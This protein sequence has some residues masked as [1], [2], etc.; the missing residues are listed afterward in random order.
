MNQPPLATQTPDTAWQS[1]NGKT[2]RHGLIED[3]RDAVGILL[4]LLVA[5][6]FGAVLSRFWAD[7]DE[8]GTSNT[9]LES[10][11]TMLESKLAHANLTDAPRLQDK[12]TRLELRL[13]MLEQSQ[14]IFG[15]GLV[16]GGAA[17]AMRSGAALA[18]F[19]NPLLETTKRVDDIGT[20]LTAVESR[21]AKTPDDIAAAKTA[22]DALT[23][24]TSGLSTRVDGM[25][26]R[27]A[28]LEASDILSLARRA[29]LAS[30][31]ANLTRAAQGS[32]PFKTEY[33]VVAALLPGET[34]LQEV[35]PYATTG[36][37]TV[38]TLISAFGSSADQAMD[39]ENQSKGD[40]WWLRLWAN[41]SSLVSWRSTAEQEG[42]STESR[43]ARAGL[44]LKSG[45][46]EAALHEL[47][48]IKGAARKPLAQW[49]TRAS[50]R[51][52]V[53]ATLASLNTQAIEAI[54]GPSDSQEPV[55]QIPMP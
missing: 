40:T 38:G 15:P 32:S 1:G 12:V 24:T 42:G 4:L 19:A 25:G 31:I 51:V 36:L 7:S 45:D 28:K 21:T 17:A 20:R 29:S 14:S 35:S 26:E 55:P 22:L 47:N 50:S 52:K 23:G 54:T 18:P 37:P 27:L 46:L 41:F 30:A 11:L 39:A 49:L 10:R 44:R 16:V 6:F 53:E 5:A 2:R 9:V 13:A 3:W 43:L 8:S 33:D 34:R 48:A